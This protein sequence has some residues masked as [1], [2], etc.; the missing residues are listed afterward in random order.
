MK[1]I[2]SA[3]LHIK[4]WSDKVIEDDG[5][6][7][8]LNEIFSTIEYMCQY[9]I[10]NGIGTCIFGGD[11]NDLKNIVHVRA[12]VLLKQLLDK[13]REIEFIILHGNHDASNYRSSESAIQLL[14]GPNN[15]HTITYPSRIENITFI[16]YSKTII[17]DIEEADPNDILISHFGLSDAE[18]SNG[19]SLKTNVSKKDLQKFKLVL[20]GHYHK[21]QS[22]D[23]IHYVGSPIQ[24]KRDEHGEDKRFFV[25][26][27]ETLEL[28]NIPT[29]GHYRK[30][31]NFIIDENYEGKPEE[32]D[33]LLKEVDQLRNDGH[34]VVVRNKLRECPVNLKEYDV[35]VVDEY[36]EEY[37][38][39][40]ITSGMTIKEQMKKYLD[41]MR[42]PEEQHERY[43]EIGLKYINLEEFGDENVTIQNKSEHV[44]DPDTGSIST[45]S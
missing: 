16:P 21:G 22:I 13:Y 12:F 25:V 33:K 9:A 3:D 38:S 32:V 29:E 15:I 43:M 7:K 44:D 35:V 37:Q 5:L 39:R 45:S 28:Q 4:L 30:Y 2:F 19:L 20:L 31:Y 8:R 42:I 40:G 24:L 6:P 11:I 1:F 17:D 18:F 34:Y 23:H 26:D 27:S 41:I 36:E 14:D 10:E